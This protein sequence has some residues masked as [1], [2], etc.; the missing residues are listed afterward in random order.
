MTSRVMVTHGNEAARTRIGLFSRVTVRAPLAAGCRAYRSCCL[1]RFFSISRKSLTSSG[2]RSSSRRTVSA[3]L[4]WITFPLSQRTTTFGPWPRSFLELGL[5]QTSLFSNRRDSLRAQQAEL[6]SHFI[7]HGDRHAM[8]LLGC[9]NPHHKR[10][11]GRLPRCP[12]RP[13]PHCIAQGNP[14]LSTFLA[15]PVPQRGHFIGSSLCSSLKEIT[16]AQSFALAFEIDALLFVGNP[17]YVLHKSWLFLRRHCL[18]KVGFVRWFTM[19]SKMSS[20]SMPRSSTEFIAVVVTIQRFC[21]NSCFIQSSVYVA[22]SMRT[23]VPKVAR[24]YH[25]SQVEIGVAGLHEPYSLL[26]SALGNRAAFSWPIA[27]MLKS[28]CQRHP[29]CPS[30]AHYLTTSKLVLAKDRKR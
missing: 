30:T 12:P 9:S 4:P 5:R 28:A 17:V 13:A 11:N 3:A 18:A 14:S 24:C 2:S 25:R 10:R 19:H 21:W 20:S 15:V 26:G 1:D 6:L 22:S 27:D 23:T 29:P 7:F 16:T 8:A